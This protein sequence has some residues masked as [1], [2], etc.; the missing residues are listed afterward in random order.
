MFSVFRQAVPAARLLLLAAAALWLA[1]CAALSPKTPEQAVSERC[2]Q[3]WE[4]L[5]SGDFDKAWTYT[6][7]GYRAI[8]KQRDYYKRFGGAGQWKG[9]RVYAAHC[10]ADRCTIRV[11]LTSTATAPPFIG[12]EITGGVDETWVREDGQW[13][14]YQSL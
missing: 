9:M 10:Q 3:R 1:G 8:I 4:A 11:A 2:Q 14:F 12:R 5:L 6:Q 7:P 13:W